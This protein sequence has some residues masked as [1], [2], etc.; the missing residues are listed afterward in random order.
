M[1]TR[2]K[3]TAQGE[4]FSV[5]LLDFVDPRHTLIELSKKINC[6]IFEVK[7]ESY[8]STD[9]WLRRRSSTFFGQRFQI[10]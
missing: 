1:K 7:F 2:K 9:F 8:S 10:F 6:E 5:E 3:K 4:L